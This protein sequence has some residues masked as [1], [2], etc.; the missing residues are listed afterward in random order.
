M[1]CLATPSSALCLPPPAHTQS[2]ACGVSAAAMF[3]QYFR[4][5][6]ACQPDLAGH[7][8]ISSRGFKLTQKLSTT[9][10]NATLDRTTKATEE[11][12]TCLQATISAVEAET[13][14][15]SEQSKLLRSLLAN[16]LPAQMLTALPAL[17]FE[18]Q[19]DMMRLFH[20]FLQAGS[21]SVIHYVSSHKEVLQVL[22][23]GCGNAE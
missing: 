23:D 10:R 9:L 2:M 21:V 18:E 6:Y 17:E 20:K 12:R 11:V 13:V 14:S 16:D 1:I 5:E 22:L 8:S 3:G 15:S 19:K 7:L 4:A